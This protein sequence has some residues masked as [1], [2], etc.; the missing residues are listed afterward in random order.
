LDSRRAPLSSSIAAWAE[1]IVE[2]LTHDY[3]F[4]YSAVFLY[5]R[6]VDALRLVGQRFVAT[7]DPGTVPIGETVVPLESVTGSVYRSGSPALL[8]DVRAHPEYR[9]FPGAVPGSE[10]AV[11]VV[12]EGRPVGV[13]NVESPRVG[14]L[15][16]ADLDRLLAAAKRAAASIPGELEPPSE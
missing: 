9:S 16:I 3:Q 14:G 1:A 10:L 13:I 7:E 4:G 11:P 6:G 2:E 12:V 8:T 15:D 5:D